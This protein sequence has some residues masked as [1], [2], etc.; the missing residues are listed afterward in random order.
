MQSQ[1]FNY[2]LEFSNSKLQTP[3]EIKD[4]SVE[5]CLRTNNRQLT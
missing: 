3:N 4:W 2:T 5:N 1:D